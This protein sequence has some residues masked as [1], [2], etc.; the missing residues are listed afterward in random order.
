MKKLIITIIAS[1][2]ESVRLALSAEQ[3]AEFNLVEVNVEQEPDANDAL[4]GQPTDEDFIPA[5]DLSEYCT[6]C[7][8]LEILHTSTDKYFCICDG[9][10][11]LGYCS[12]RRF[13]S[14]S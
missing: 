2:G 10:D 6:R 8:H 4:V 14:G 7:D 9:D 11:G 3:L 1:K 13:I 12:C 5:L